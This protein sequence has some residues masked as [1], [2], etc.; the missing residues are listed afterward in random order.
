VYEW[1]SVKTCIYKCKFTNWKER[2]KNELTGSSPLRR[3]RSALGFSAIEEEKEE[4]GEEGEEETWSATL[5]EERRFTGS[6]NRVLKKIFR[7]KK[8]R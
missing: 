4:D 1:N 7:P 6:E 2:S 3:S 5:K 8:K